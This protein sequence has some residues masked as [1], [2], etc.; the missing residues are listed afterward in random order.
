MLLLKYTHIE[1]LKGL[2]IASNE[3]PATSQPSDVT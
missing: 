2:V 3:D 1:M